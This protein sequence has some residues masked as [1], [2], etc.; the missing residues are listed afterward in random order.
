MPR[1]KLR[2]PNYRLKL[3]GR[4]WT[5]TWTEPRDGKSHTRAVSTGQ[6]DKAR[7]EVWCDQYLAGLGQPEPPQ[8]PLIADILDGYLADRKKAGVAAY[9]RLEYA[10]KAVK[11]H[12]G[13]LEPHMVGR[14]AYTEKRAQEGVGDGT[15]LREVVVLRAALKWAVGENWIDKAPAITAPANPP[16]RERWLTRDEVSRLIAACRAQHLRLFVLLAYHT[17]ARRG[18][19][20]ELTWDRVDFEARRIDYRRP[21]RRETNKRRAIVPLNAVVLAE[22]QRVRKAAIARAER[23]GEEGNKHEQ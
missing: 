3:R 7:A 9:E 10:A 14:R 18:A 13:N 16:P 19:I 4:F 23:R 12:L 22:L 5:L 20:L 21:G 8:Q 1:P 11:R 6:A 17:A 2:E 15:M